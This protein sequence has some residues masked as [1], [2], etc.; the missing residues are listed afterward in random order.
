[1]K[2]GRTKH[3][4]PPNFRWTTDERLSQFPSY[5]LDKIYFGDLDNYFLKD[6]LC[7]F[8]QSIYELL[9]YEEP[10]A[11]G[12]RIRWLQGEPESLFKLEEKYRKYMLLGRSW[13]DSQ[14]YITA[15]NVY[16]TEANH[17]EPSKYYCIWIDSPLY[18]YLRDNEEAILSQDLA[19]S[20]S[21]KSSYSGFM[22]WAGGSKSGMLDWRVDRAS[23][24][25]NH[26]YRAAASGKF[27][28]VRNYYVVAA[29]Y[30]RKTEIKRHYTSAFEAFKAIREFTQTS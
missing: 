7:G 19:T 22:N 17:A 27:C 30:K 11:H 20:D 25:T 8:Y 1:L 12:K 10:Y 29:L 5:V 26:G 4:D 6:L 14:E 2:T 24:T 28:C 13:A 18:C 9:H 16:C 21:R 23:G 3:E 15:L